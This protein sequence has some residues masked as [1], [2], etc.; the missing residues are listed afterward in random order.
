MSAFSFTRLVFLGLC[1]VTTLWIPTVY[2]SN[3]NTNGNRLEEILYQSMNP[4]LDK[5][6]AIYF[7]EGFSISPIFPN[8]TSSD[9]QLRY[10]LDPSADAQVILRNALGSIVK[11]YIL[12]PAHNRIQLNLPE[13]KPGMYIYSIKHNKETVVSKPLIIRS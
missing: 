8:P 11:V 13:L 3:G 7:S 5:A 6:D 12:N 9:A 4:P 1:L 10:M 2:G